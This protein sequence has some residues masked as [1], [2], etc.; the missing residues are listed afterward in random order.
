MAK[1]VCEMC[2]YE[3]VSQEN[4][5]YVCLACGYKSV[6][7]ITNGNNDAETEADRLKR[8]RQ[9][10]IERIVAEKKKKY[11]KTGITVVASCICAVIAFIIILNSPPVKYSK[12]M[13]AIEKQDYVK[14]YEILIT[15]ENYKDSATKIDNIKPDYH[16]ALM[17]NA[18]VG[19]IVKFGAYEQDGNFANGKED[20]EWEILSKEGNKVLLLS[21]NVLD[22]QPYHTTDIDITWAKCSL[23][24]WLNSTFYNNAFNTLCQDYIATTLVAPSTVSNKTN[25]GTA[26][27]DK[28]FLLSD[29]EL[30]KY[31]PD[32]YDRVQGETKHCG[33]TTCWW[34]RTT[35]QYQSSACTV[36]RYAV[37]NKESYIGTIADWQDVDESWNGVCPAIWVELD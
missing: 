17:K 32:R 29:K 8:E 30:E 22:E 11:I 21:K 34:L 5:G 28:V 9:K 31:V 6:P 1:Y 4:G 19:D 27:N 7:N 14:A 23:R 35:G 10:E 25:P 37:N 12:A 3:D 2:G 33:Y 26:T 13:S 18:S 24:T 16:I 20:I 36:W 15:I